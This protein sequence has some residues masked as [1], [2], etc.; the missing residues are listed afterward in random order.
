MEQFECNQKQK[1]CTI[2]DQT[3]GLTDDIAFLFDVTKEGLNFQFDFYTFFA[4]FGK[5]NKHVI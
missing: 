3:G 4:K 2:F 5:S 1:I